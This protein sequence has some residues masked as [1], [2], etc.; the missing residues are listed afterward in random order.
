MKTGAEI[1]RHT[2]LGME[3][4]LSMNEWIY[5]APLSHSRSRRSDPLVNPLVHVRR[6]F[7]TRYF[8]CIYRRRNRI[9]YSVVDRWAGDSSGFAEF[10][11][12]YNIWWT[13]LW[14][15]K[16]RENGL[17]WFDLYEGDKGYVLLWCTLQGRKNGGIA[18]AVCIASICMFLLRSIWIYIYM[19]IMDR[20]R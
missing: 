15:M 3:M 17:V 5:T 16:R 19:Y 8:V 12:Q 20:R 18:Y 13:V 14:C 2:P 4:E 11:S 9:V 7:R 6:H 10:C 1:D